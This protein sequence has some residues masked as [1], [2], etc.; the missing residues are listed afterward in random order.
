MRRMEEAYFD[1][2]AEIALIYVNT[3]PL[4][5]APMRWSNKTECLLL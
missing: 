4:C 5:A 3:S 1:I 2:S